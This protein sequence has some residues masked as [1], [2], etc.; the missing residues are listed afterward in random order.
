MKGPGSL[1]IDTF[2]Y[3]EVG[4][5]AVLLKVLYSGRELATAYLPSMR[6]MASSLDRLPLRTIVT[7]RLAL[8]DA[9]EA[10]E[11]AQSDG[12]MKVVIAPHGTNG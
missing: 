3:P 9:Q 6:L 12:A 8:E 11:L 4:P 1:E 5:G 10:V 7:H 2:P